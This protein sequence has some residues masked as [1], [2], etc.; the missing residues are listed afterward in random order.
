M[1]LKIHKKKIS[2][3]LLITEDINHIRDIDSLLDRI[4]SEAR[5]FTNADAGSIYLARGNYLSFDYVQNDT[6][7]KNDQSGNHFLYSN[8][9]IEIDDN[10][11]AGYVAKTKE[12]LVINDVYKLNKRVP[13]TFNQS[14]DRQSSYKT[15][16]I[17]TVPLIT[18]RDKII[19]VMQIINPKK[20]SKI[21]NFNI[22]DKLLVT[23]F[24]S[25]AAVA[26][27]RAII[28]R[29]TILRMIRMAEMRD[30]KET[31]AHV[32]RVGAYAI[33]IFNSWALKKNYSLD[34]I[35]KYKDILRIAAMLHDVGKIGIPDAILRKNG[36]LN[37]E[38][39]K[40]IKM[41]TI[42]G[43]QLFSE[44]SSESDEVAAEIALNHHEKWNGS[45][46]PGK[47]TKSSKGYSFGKGKKGDEIPLSARIVAL[48]DVYDALFSQR[49]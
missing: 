49:S 2:D 11:I 26:V 46:Y 13:Y 28:T 8:F 18:S 7:M 25:Q 5:K 30:P 14:F 44:K 6:L 22:N 36:K 39:Y 15:K 4:L 35:K 9:K 10:S 21:I 19:G 43:M 12:P 20:H 27:E 37:E 42:Y 41:H 23:Y 29:E 32:N 40:A 33:E 1:E 34:E 45:G 17:L 47:Y 16:S 31:G 48:A 38:E 3:I 24:A